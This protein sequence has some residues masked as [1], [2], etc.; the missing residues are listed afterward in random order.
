M[1]QGGK[2]TITTVN[3]EL[4]EVYARQHPAVIPGSYVMFAVSDTGCGMDARP[5]RTFSNLFY[6]Q[7]IG[8]G[9]AW[10]VDVYDCA[11]ERGHIGYSEPGRGSTSGFISLGL[12]RP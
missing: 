12:R 10:A 9:R 5:R 2:L 3:E 11:A 7:G 1:P 4:D 6:H 8:K